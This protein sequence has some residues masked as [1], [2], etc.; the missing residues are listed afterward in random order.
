L[1]KQENKKQD[2]GLPW[3][4]KLALYGGIAGGGLAIVY[5]LVNNIFMGSVN[6]YK[7]MWVKQYDALLQKMANYTKS[8]PD[9]WTTTQQLNVNTEEKIL[10]QT[11]KGLANATSN[12]EDLGVYIIAGLTAIGITA[13]ISKAALSYFRSRSG[14]QVRTAA[15]AGYIAIMSFADYMN[16]NGAPI[17]AENLVSVSRTMFEAYDLPYMQQVTSSLQAQLPNLV[18]VQLIVAQQAIEALTIEAAVIP[19]LLSAPLPLI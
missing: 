19:L 11:T 18:G 8:N 10:D 2:K 7:D 4:G 15:G 16:A 6:T 1:S 9:G 14:G 13:V 17:Y 3:W 5:Y 12:L